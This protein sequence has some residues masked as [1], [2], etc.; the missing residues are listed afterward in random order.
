MQFNGPF[1]TLRTLRYLMR[2]KARYLPIMKQ[3][4]WT[5]QSWTEQQ[6]VLV[7]LL[8]YQQ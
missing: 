3:M 1:N 5:V 2:E 8:G 7:Q 6:A 4:K